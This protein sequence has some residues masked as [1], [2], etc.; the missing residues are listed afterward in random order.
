MAHI[1][2]IVDIGIRIPMRDGVELVADL[3]LPS[4]EGNWPTILVRCPYDRT[5]P[6]MGSMVIVDPAWLARQG[7]AVVVQ[8]T[9]GRGES[10]GQFDPVYQEIDDGYDTVEWA[11]AQSWSTG[12]VGIYGSSY[13]G[14][15]AYQAV[16]SRAPHLRAAV[17][18]VA[19]PLSL[20]HRRNGG[21]FDA[22]FMTWYAYLTAMMT[23]S[24]SMLPPEEKAGL[25]ERI[26]AA[27]SDPIGAAEPLPLS[28]LDVLSDDAIAPFWEDWLWKDGPP[29]TEERRLLGDVADIGDVALLHISGYRDLLADHAFDLATKLAGNERHRFVA[30]PWTHRGPYSGYSGCRELPGTSTPAGPLGW[31]PLLVAWFDIHLRGGTAESHPYANPWIEGGGVRYYLE[32]ANRWET[33]QNWPP[34]TT[35]SEWHLTSGGNAQS[36][37]GD[38]RLLAP[39]VNAPGN[40]VDRFIADPHDPV[41]TCGGAL[42]IPEQ[43]PEGIQDQRSIDGRNDILVFT[44]DVLETP[45][46]IAGEQELLLYF[47]SDAPDADICVTLVDV[48]PGGFAYNVSEGS[49]RTRYRSGGTADWLTRGVQHEITVKLHNTAHLFREGHRI[50]VMIAGANYPRLSRNLHTKTLPELGSMQ[51]AVPAVHAVYHGPAHPSRLVLRTVKDE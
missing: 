12:A 4:T 49:V 9:R 38:G 26:V 32:G 2:M 23:V 35:A 1:R 36:A 22:C 18:L 48:E 39:G 24:R 15:A 14:V 21:I 29:T 19:T 11:A 17:A 51:E 16:A 7:F 28:K 44:S 43:G 5:D 13:M 42:G 45:V 27:L 41:P 3:Y 34:P 10:E 40:G 20:C 30:G 33:A 6:A 47:A 31:G 37:T 46:H 50:R 8:D 25:L